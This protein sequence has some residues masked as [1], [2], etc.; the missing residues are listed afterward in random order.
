MIFKK[1]CHKLEN[2]YINIYTHI[3]YLLLIDQNQIPCKCNFINKRVSNPS[4]I[5]T[6]LKELDHSEQTPSV[7]S[8]GDWTNISSVAVDWTPVSGLCVSPA[9]A[10]I[11]S[12]RY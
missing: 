10:V 11:V 9:L 8:Y 12:D 3:L 6:C 7:S 4:M 1:A 5:S 2:I